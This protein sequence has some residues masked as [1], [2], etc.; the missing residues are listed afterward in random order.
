[1]PQKN[2]YEEI[3]IPEGVDVEITK[4]KIKI[5]KEG[6]EIERKFD[7]EIKKQDGKLI[8]EFKKPDKNDKKMIKTMIAHLNNMLKGINEKYIYKLQICTV[9]FPMNIKIEGNEVIIK[10]FLGEVKD[11]KARIIEGVDIK[12]DGEII[13]V[14][15]CDKEKA[16]QTAANIE[17]ATKIKKRDRR[18]FQDGI[19]II[20]K[21]KG[22]KRK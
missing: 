14:E 20:E 2:I 15:S 17:S 22:R 11:R 16:G 10:N 3:K 19:Y 1:M 7:Y 6:N 4:E 8:I 18:I 13:T 9:H 12:I 21:Q 5:S